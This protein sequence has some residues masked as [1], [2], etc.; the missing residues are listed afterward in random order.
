MHYYRRL[1]IEPIPPQLLENLELEELKTVDDIGYGNQYIDHSGER[2][3]NASYSLYKVSAETE[4]AAWLA[5]KFTNF[6][7]NFYWKLQCSQAQNNR[8][9]R[10][11]AHTDVNRTVAI[12]YII[13]TGGERV[14]TNWYRERGQ[15]THRGFKQPGELVPGKTELD[16]SELELLESVECLAGSWYMIQTD[17]IHDVSGITGLRRSLSYGCNNFWV[18]TFRAELFNW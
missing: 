2:I 13:D 15:S 1:D 14:R 3:E 18:N 12:N 8:E 11:I 16:Y 7:P 5:T 6:L 9:S 17:V 4:L 10:H